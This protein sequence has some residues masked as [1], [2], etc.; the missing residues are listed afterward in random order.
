MGILTRRVYTT[1]CDYC[2]DS[3]TSYTE[4]D[5]C[6]DGGRECHCGHVSSDEGDL[7]YTIPKYRWV[8]WIVNYLELNVLRKYL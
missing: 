3:I 4:P 1:Y 8:W 7:Y 5:K 2:G 6:P